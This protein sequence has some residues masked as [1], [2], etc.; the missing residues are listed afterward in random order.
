MTS[1]FTKGRAGTNCKFEH[2]ARAA[3]TEPVKGKT[4][5]QPLKIGKDVCWHFTQGKCNRGDKCKKSHANPTGTQNPFGNSA[6]ALGTAATNPFGKQQILQTPS[7]ADAASQQVGTFNFAAEARVGGG[8]TAKR[9]AAPALK[10]KQAF[11]Q[12]RGGGGS[13][14]QSFSGT[15]R[16]LGVAAASTALAPPPFSA[17]LRP[18]DIPVTSAFGMPQQQQQQQGSFNFAKAAAAVRNP[19]S[20]DA[21][22]TA[23]QAKIMQAR[24]KQ[25]A[26]RV[27]REKQQQLIAQKQ[28]Q[29]IAQKQQ[30]L[31]VQ[32][33][34]QQAAKERR[35]AE[36][37][38]VK[39]QQ[40]EEERR[41]QQEE[42]QRL[43]EEERIVQLQQEV[44]RRA[45]E[46]RLA[47]E[48]ERIAAIKFAELA[49]QRAQLQRKA[50]E[51][52]RAATRRK[53][54]EEQAELQ[55]MQAELVRLEE[56]A[57]ALLRQQHQE[58]EEAR[59]AEARRNA[60]QQQMVDDAISSTMWSC[61]EEAIVRP[62]AVEIATEHVYSQFPSCVAVSTLASSANATA[63]AAARPKVRHAPFS[64][65]NDGAAAASLMVNGRSRSKRQRQNSSQKSS[66]SDSGGGRGGKNRLPEASKRRR[67]S[68]MSPAAA[69]PAA[70]PGPSYLQSLASAVNA[71]D[72]ALGGGGSSSGGGSG[73]TAVSVAAIASP[74]SRFRAAAAAAAAAGA[75]EA[76][77]PLA[78][79]S[80]SPSKRQRPMMPSIDLS[81][82]QFATKALVFC[83]WL[84]D[85]V[86]PAPY[87]NAKKPA[88]G[89]GDRQLLLDAPGVKGEVLEQRLMQVNT[90]LYPV[91]K[92]DTVECDLAF[93][94]GHA[95]RFRKVF[96]GLHGRD[97]VK[98]YIIYSGWDAVGDASV[99][100]ATLQR[101]LD[102]DR[103]H[104]ACAVDV[105][106]VAYGT[107][108]P[109]KKRRLGATTS[110]PR[111]L[112][113]AGIRA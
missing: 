26:A 75:P 35:M 65:E 54:E 67:R 91:A 111:T 25:E 19:G 6:T 12:S 76:A 38:A 80:M 81:R 60:E 79:M 57:A 105:V 85:G 71:G 44:I 43:A 4:K 84:G 1:R 18:T 40:E 21:A 70:T 99:I 56:E 16:T 11:A 50:E 14:L 98:L 53:E 106:F 58:Q 77:R 5:T 48:H 90:I 97:S 93:W 64:A 31:V 36:M 27:Q 96:A 109:S 46:A 61:L 32:K 37:L 103:I 47:E 82:M 69:S 41:I 62:T 20:P 51:A 2:A 104:G 86:E 9:S 24:Q 89:P 55:R 29:L 100:H 113:N 23:E 88:G 73:S 63:A 78:T 7:A 112:R 74:F 110:R 83:R 22:L 10:A 17:T 28:Q 39:R 49:R 107:P 66:I 13:M 59:L 52:A 92:P 15:V 30:Q 8:Q 94:A 68:S 33:Q 3:G 42:T 72:L 102:L 101:G 34:K 45:A 95:K 87:R 108:S